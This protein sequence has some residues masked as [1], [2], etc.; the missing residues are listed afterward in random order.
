MWSM[1]LVLSGTGT[2]RQTLE[3]AVGVRPGQACPWTTVHNIGVFNDYNAQAQY[4]RRYVPM[5]SN[6][7]QWVEFLTRA[8]AWFRGR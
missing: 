4:I 2:D 1:S 3:N 8:W 5:P 7:P 6:D